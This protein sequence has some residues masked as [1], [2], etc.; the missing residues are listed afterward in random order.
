[1]RVGVT[2]ATGFVGRAIVTA[3]RRR[4][5]EVTVLTRD[6]AASSMPADVLVTRF[7]A[8]ETEPN[9]APF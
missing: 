2:G 3:L 9:P 1:M 7:D 8:N 5:D 4:G 6:P